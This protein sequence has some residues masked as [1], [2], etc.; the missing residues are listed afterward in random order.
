M[1][2]MSASVCIEASAD[3]VWRRLAKL[4]DI[5]LWAPGIRRAT[6]EGSHS[7][8]VGARRRCVLVSNLVIDERWTAW[9]EGR[10]FTYEGSGLPLVKRAIN[11]WSIVPA[12]G[13]LSLLKT[14]ALVEL[15]GGVFGRCL[16]SVMRLMFKRMGRSSLAAFKYLVEHG[17]PYSGRISDLPRGAATC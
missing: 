14:D 8:G 2:R 9:E 10:S 11:T 7:H 13:G 6:C 16:E 3:A 15:E 12:P 17:H 5:Q 4:E 1:I